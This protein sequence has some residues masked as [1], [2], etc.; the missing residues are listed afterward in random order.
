MKTMK[1]FAS[2]LVV[3]ALVMS[4]A[5]TAFAATVTNE[6]KHNYVAYQILSGTQAEGSVE[7]GNVVW[8]SGVDGDAL[9]AALQDACDYFD[10]CATAQD[11]AN[12]LSG[13]ADNCAE[14]KKLADVAASVAG[15]LKDVKT[16]IAAGAAS[17]EL[18]AG[19]WL[20]VDVTA[21]GV[22]DAKNAAL[23]Q[24]TND[25]DITIATK[26]NAP[27]VDKTVNDNDVNI[28]DTVE[29]T[30]TATM[31][32]MLE[33]YDT[34]KVIF[35][36]TMSAGLT[37]K[38]L[39]S[40]TVDGGSDVKSSFVLDP[41]VPSANATT[42]ET[43]FTVSC[44]NVLATAV[45]ATAGSKIVVTYTAV[46]DQ[47]AVIGT[48]GNPN[49]VHLEYSNDPN[50]N[51]TDNEPTGKT[52][53]D[54]VKVYTWQIPVFKYINGENGPEGLAGAGFTL[55]KDEAC[56]EGKEV[57][58]SPAKDEE[59]QTIANVY[60]VDPQGTVTEIKTDNTGRFE[61]EG[62]E[63]GTYYLKETTTPAG[64]N[65]CGNVTVTI[66]EDGVLTVGEDTVTEVAILNQAGTVIPETGGMGTTIFYVCGGIMVLAAVVLLV[67]KRR[68]HTAK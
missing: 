33:G 61:I 62:L 51:G 49:K 67:T 40:V 52:P 21:P 46:V 64:Y 66:G 3:L 17:V 41:V 26:A 59:G 44:E 48:E 5:T 50:W 9:L 7:L 38:E 47:D 32:S 2:L 55:Y 13:K 63:K 45:G 39:V 34:Y 12:V 22:G 58:L 29:F 27:T 35:H 18:A 16:E 60:K 28:G 6:N 37:F 14:A 19:Y 53:E 4:L 20:L 15:C 24:V 1:K 42:G 25:G 11:V 65:T 68:M 10:S 31:P 54:E 57:K 30:L 56:T 8:G 23:L 36:D 43:E